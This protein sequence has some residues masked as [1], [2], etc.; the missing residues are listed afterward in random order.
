[1]KSCYLVVD[2]DCTGY[3]VAINNFFSRHGSTDGKCR[4]R[5]LT[6]VAFTTQNRHND[7]SIKLKNAVNSYTVR[8]PYLYK[9]QVLLD[10][11]TGCVLNG[12]SPRQPTDINSKV[13]FTTDRPCLSETFN[14]WLNASKW[15]PTRSETRRFTTCAARCQDTPP[16]PA[17]TTVPST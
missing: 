8:P 10:K 5:G 12:E 4:R 11:V 1:M 14:K 16:I 9:G 13:F 7:D 6:A 15:T 3:E 17:T 2:L